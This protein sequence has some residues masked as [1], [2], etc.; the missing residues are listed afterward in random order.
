MSDDCDNDC[1]S[2]TFHVVEMIDDTVIEED[3]I[4][5]E[6]VV[7]ALKYLKLKEDQG[8]SLSDSLDFIHEKGLNALEMS[9]AISVHFLAGIVFNQVEFH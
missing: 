8:Q 6:L 2:C 4:R 5:G 7:Q 1:D 9:E 3:E